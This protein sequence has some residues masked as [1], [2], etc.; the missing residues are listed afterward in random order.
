MRHDVPHYVPHNLRRAFWFTVRDVA[1]H[2]SRAFCLIMY[3]VLYDVDPDVAPIAA[4]SSPDM[5]LRA[6]TMLVAMLVPIEKGF[7]KGKV[8]YNSLRDVADDVAHT[9][10]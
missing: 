2:M 8:G 7:E 5:I 3:D 1:H 4:M 9:G 10:S 6:S